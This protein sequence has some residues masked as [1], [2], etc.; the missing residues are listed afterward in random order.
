MSGRRFL[1]QSLI[2]ARGLPALDDAAMDALRRILDGGELGATR[3]VA[4]SHALLATLAPGGRDRLALVAGFIRDSRGVEAPVVAVGVGWL[5]DT[6]DWSRDGLL[7][8]AELWA[9]NLNARRR[10]LVEKAAA[11]LAGQTTFVLFDYSGTVADVI[12]ARAAQSPCRLVIPESRP[13]DGGRRYL[14]A[15]ASLQMPTRFCFDAALDS[16]LAAVGQDSALLLG[17]ES[18][19]P[20]GD[21]I[22]TIGSTASARLASAY[23]VPT[24]GCAERIKIDRRAPGAS[25]PPPRRDFRSVLLPG[26]GPAGF[27]VDTEQVEL[28]RVP[29]SLLAGIF[30]ERGCERPET[31]AAERHDG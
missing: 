30:T 6:S 21:L 16:E 18:L 3:H 14:E 1:L 2:E 23:G 4:L 5:L 24:F 22:N 31:L 15:L 20:N 12:R 25:L 11:H 19:R 9:A 28:E 17:A 29:A 26:G 27:P 13:L 8:R 10:A 7:V